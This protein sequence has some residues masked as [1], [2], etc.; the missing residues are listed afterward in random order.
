MNNAAVAVSVKS[1]HRKKFT[2]I[3]IMGLIFVVSSW[4]RSSELGFYSDDWIFLS[5][6]IHSPTTL[7]AY[8]AANWYARP[9]YSLIA[10]SLNLL[11]TGSAIYWQIIS[12]AAVLASAVVSYKII[13]YT[14]GR[15]G[16]GTWASL[17]GGTYGAAVL[18]FSPWMIAVLVWST[19]VLTLWSFILFGTGYLIVEQSERFREKCVGSFLILAGF[20]TYEAYW[21]AF[22]PLLL[23]SKTPSASQVVSTIRSALWHLAPLGLAVIYQR[24]LVPLVA[25]GAA[26]IISPNFSLMLN[27]IRKFDHFISQAIAPIST[28][29][30]YLTL[31][32]LIAFL[33]A[34]RAVTFLKFVLVVA[35]LGLGVLFTAVMHGAVGYG[36]AGTGVMSRTMAAP[37][38]YFAIFLG[39]LAAAAAECITQKHR[40]IRHAYVALPLFG[41][42]FIITLFGFFSRLNSWISWKEQSVRVLDTLAVVVDETYLGNSSKDIAIVVQID[43]DPNGEIF[44]ASWELSGAVALTV[45]RLMPANGVWFLTARQSAWGTVWD[46]ESVIQTVCS[47][48]PRSVVE[49]RSSHEPPLY[50]RI[51]PRDGKIIESGRLIKDIPFGCEGISPTLAQF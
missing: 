2:F 14:A 3:I 6:T 49:H 5:N 20:L 45:P 25:P 51:N 24:V 50:Y 16:Y 22:I 23:I 31:L 43:G 38:F 28:N 10:W 36:L 1:G 26:K 32:A 48:P 8:L 35:A 17:L 27:N 12:S 4:W 19:G 33:L 30:F 42:I 29:A 9:V 44:G 41:I 15:L 39:I 34:I 37:G 21:F 7:A 40:V 46:G 47:T 18:F 11:A 13:V